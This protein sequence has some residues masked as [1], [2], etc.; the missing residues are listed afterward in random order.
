MKSARPGRCGRAPDRRSRPGTAAGVIMQA[1]A[2]Q[3]RATGGSVSERKRSF[4]PS[5][6]ALA[7]SRPGRDRSPVAPQAL[8]IS[9]DALGTVRRTA[10]CRFARLRVAGQARARMQPPQ[11]TALG[12]IAA[13]PWPAVERDEARPAGVLPGCLW[14]PSGPGRPAPPID[15]CRAIR[16]RRGGT[17]A[18]RH[19]AARWPRAKF[20]S[21]G[22]EVGWQGGRAGRQYPEMCDQRA[23]VAH[24]PSPAPDMLSVPAWTRWRTRRAFGR[25]R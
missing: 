12:P 13:P 15:P 16:D 14:R 25:P 3:R 20:P 6:R 7:G 8:A 23:Q 17:R 5:H 24:Q 4:R 18:R 1:T 19:A 11:G 9:P 2:P 10:A 21:G 22:I